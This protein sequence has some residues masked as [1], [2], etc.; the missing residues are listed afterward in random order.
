MM[1]RGMTQAELAAR[2]SRILGETISRSLVSM[3]LIGERT[4]D[5]RQARALSKALSG[6]VSPK[7]WTDYEVP[8][9]ALRPRKRK[10]R[11]SRRGSSVS[12]R[13]AKQEPL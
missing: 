6:A 1:E 4:P 10:T 2:A 11:A 13:P 7:E 3:F 9:D 12:V 5:L 8:G